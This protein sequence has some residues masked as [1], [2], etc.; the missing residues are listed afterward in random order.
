MEKANLLTRQMKLALQA[1]HTQVQFIPNLRTVACLEWFSP[2]MYA[3]HW[4]PTL[5]KKAGGINVFGREQAP[6]QTLKWQE[7]L[8]QNPDVILINL[9]GFSINQ[10]IAELPHLLASPGWETLRAVAD[11]QVYILDGYHYFNRPGPRI[12]DSVEMLGEILHPEL[13][14][15]KYHSI[16]WINLNEVMK[17]GELGSI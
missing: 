3:G 7:L 13:F 14:E 12:V 8:D 16:G 17:V 9:R 2:L 15:T 5:I 10:S 11:E 1:V 6:S 4:M